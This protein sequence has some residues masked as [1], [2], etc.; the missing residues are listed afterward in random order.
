MGMFSEGFADD[1]LHRI[2]LE[3]FCQS[4]HDFDEFPMRR[5][6]GGDFVE[7][8]QDA[9]R[10][11]EFDQFLQIV[12]G[13]CRW[14]LPGRDRRGGGWTPAA[15]PPASRVVL[16]RHTLLP[17]APTISISP[18]TRFLPARITRAVTIAS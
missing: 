17:S 12:Q 2:E 4:S 11:A 15:P 18:N 3:L 7:L 6:G 1:F 5:I 13:L 16:A 9:A 8:V 14:R 10:I